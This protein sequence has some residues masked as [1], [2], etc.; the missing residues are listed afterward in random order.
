MYSNCCAVCAERENE[1]F[2]NIEKTITLPAHYFF[3]Q[4]VKE[5]LRLNLSNE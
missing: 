4:A 5:I 1:M 2:D 3:A